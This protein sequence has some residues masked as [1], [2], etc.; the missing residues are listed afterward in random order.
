MKRM[1][2]DRKTAL[3]V[4]LFFIIATAAGVLG[5]VSAGPVQAE[6]YLVTISDNKNQVLLGTVFT[7]IMA[8]AVAGIAV[9][10]YPVLKKKSESLALGYVGARIIEGVVMIATVFSWLLLL[11]LSRE[12]VEAGMPAASHF[13]TFGGILR[14]IGGWAGHVVLDVV[15]SPIHYLILY[16]LL[17][18]SRLVPRWLS[19]WGLLGIPIWLLAGV[20]AMLGHDPSSG[21]AVVLNLPIAV[22]EMVLAIWLIAKGFNVSAPEREV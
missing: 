2:K 8:V 14:S 6:N 15:V 19:L 3:L 13:Q 1:S 10:A 7:L 5:A 9:A 16:S 4:G 12:F 18:S 22:N 21:F 11:V 17:F 20:L